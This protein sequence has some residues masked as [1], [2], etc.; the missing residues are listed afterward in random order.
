MRAPGTTFPMPEP[1]LIYHGEMDDQ[2]ITLDLRCAE[3]E[4]LEQRLH[5]EIM[6]YNDNQCMW[7]AYKLGIL[8]EGERYNTPEIAME[9]L[10][11]SDG[12][13]LSDK[14]KRSVTRD[15]IISLSPKLY[16]DDQE[17][18]GKIVR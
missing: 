12:L 3:N 9:M 7:L 14:L 16:L 10:L 13:F 2:D 11:L 1:S 4:V 18:D 15:E 6:L 8:N 17:I 5:P